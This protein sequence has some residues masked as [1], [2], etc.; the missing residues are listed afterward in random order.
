MPYSPQPPYPANALLDCA[1]SSSITTLTLPHPHHVK[2]GLGNHKDVDEK[3]VGKS[4]ATDKAKAGNGPRR[5]SR[6]P[7]ATSLH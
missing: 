3:G 2:Q 6:M 5:T 1:L 7:P 4:K